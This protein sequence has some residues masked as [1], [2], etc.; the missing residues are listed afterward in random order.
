MI[1]NM[2]AVFMNM[3]Y[4]DHQ[5]AALCCALASDCNLVVCY[6]CLGNKI[7]RRKEQFAD[8]YVLRS[9][10]LFVKKKLYLNIY[11]CSKD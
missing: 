7:H 4:T 8:G 9:H 10:C 6:A 11:N 3:L 2:L 1:V 5:H